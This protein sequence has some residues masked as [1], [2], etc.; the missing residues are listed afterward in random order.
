MKR[1]LNLLVG[2]A[3]VAVV[4]GCTAGEGAPALSGEYGEA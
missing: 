2:F 3:V 1:K 4:G